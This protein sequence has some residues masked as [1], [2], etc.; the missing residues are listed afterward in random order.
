MPLY[1][2]LG[3][4]ICVAEVSLLLFNDIASVPDVSRQ[5]S[6]SS[7]TTKNATATFLERLAKDYA[8]IWCHIREEREKKIL[9]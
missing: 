3:Y 1:D 7:W 2:F 9:F 8:V 5:C 6:V 4:H